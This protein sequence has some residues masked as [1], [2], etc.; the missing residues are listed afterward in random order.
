MKVLIK[1]EE[2][3]QT[4]K[5]GTPQS[6]GYDLIFKGYVNN[7]DGVYS[8]HHSALEKDFG[9]LTGITIKPGG[10]VLVTTGVK[11]AIPEGYEIQVRPRSGLALKQGLTVLNTPGTIDSD[12]RGDIGVIVVNHSTEEQRLSVGDKIAQIVLQKVE[13]IDWEIVEE[14]PET[15]RGEGGFGSTGKSLN[16]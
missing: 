4:P 5:Q 7:Y 16:S 1:T 14:L 9:V 6:S 11:V 13:K 10:R 8:V 2:G 15:F 3:V 12:Y